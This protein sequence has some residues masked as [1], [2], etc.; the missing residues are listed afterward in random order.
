MDRIDLTTRAASLVRFCSRTPPVQKRI[1]VA[2][3]ASARVLRFL[4]FLLRSPRHSFQHKV[5]LWKQLRDSF[6]IHFYK[7]CF[8]STPGHSSC[9]RMVD[10][11]LV[12]AVPEEDQLDVNHVMPLI[13]TAKELIRNDFS[14][15][16]I[17]EYIGDIIQATK[18]LERESYEPVVLQKGCFMYGLLFELGVENCFN[19]DSKIVQNLQ[20]FSIL[21]HEQ[22][23]E[24]AVRYYF[25][26]HPF[27][28]R[29]IFRHDS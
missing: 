12:A 10:Y 9:I 17:P 5:D 13:S 25:E 28:T 20:R 14:G 24:K 16:K 21:M 2:S 22:N 3:V 4:S 7:E 8:S 26:R 15:T 6:H 1:E 19:K 11:L 23:E 29:K 18:V 27:C